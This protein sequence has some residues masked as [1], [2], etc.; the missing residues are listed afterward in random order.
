MILISFSTVLISRSAVTSSAFRSMAS[1][2]AKVS[3][4]ASRPDFL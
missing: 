3:V 2:A 1:A 4:S